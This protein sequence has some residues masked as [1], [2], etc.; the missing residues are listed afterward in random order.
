MFLEPLA[1]ELKLVAALLQS[2]RGSGLEAAG[3]DVHDVREQVVVD[4]RLGD[5]AIHGHLVVD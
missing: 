2:T 1:G 5:R 4:P 3:L